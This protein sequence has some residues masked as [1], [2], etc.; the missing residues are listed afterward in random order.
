MS[1]PQTI[2]MGASMETEEGL[3]IIDA[4][5]EVTDVLAMEG[6][7]VTF[8]ADPPKAVSGPERFAGIALYRCPRGA[9]LFFQE[10]DGPHWGVALPS[11]LL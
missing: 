8:V 3:A 2:Q 9:F 4:L 6:E 7:R 5:N 1:Q 10:P 11:T